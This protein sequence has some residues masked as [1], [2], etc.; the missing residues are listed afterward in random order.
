MSTIH[1]DRELR[2]YLSLIQH[3]GWFVAHCGLL[4]ASAA[5]AASKL[6]TPIYRATALLLEEPPKTAQ[7]PYSAIL[8]G[9]Q[10]VSTTAGVLLVW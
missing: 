6:H 10:L 8:A 9:D 7:D 2:H 1:K 3:W 4:A 5:F